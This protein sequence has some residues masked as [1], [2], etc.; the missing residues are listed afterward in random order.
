MLESK[1]VLALIPARGGSKGI[2]RKNIQDLGGHPLIW[3]SIQAALGSAYA[4]DCFVSTDDEEIAEVARARSAWVPFLRPAELAQDGSKTIDCMVEGLARLAEIGRRYDIVVLLQATSPFRTAADLDRALER[5]EECGERGLAPIGEVDV[6]PILMRTMAADGTLS[7][8]LAQGSTVR[9]R[10]MPT[11]HTVNGAIYINRAEEIRPDTSLNDNPVGWVLDRSR[12]LGIDEPADL[13]E[14]RK[15]I[16]QHLA[17]NGSL[18]VRV[19]AVPWE[20][21]QPRQ[22]AHEVPDAHDVHD[23]TR[24]GLEKCEA[25]GSVARH[26]KQRHHA[27][28]VEGEA[29][30]HVRRDGEWVRE[31]L[32][33]AQPPHQEGHEAREPQHHLEVVEQQAHDGAPDARD[34]AMG[35]RHAV[36]VEG[37]DEDDLELHREDLDD[38]Q[39]AVEGDEPAPWRCSRRGTSPRSRRAPPRGWRRPSGR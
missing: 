27:V 26:V 9:R 36:S 21:L 33:R 10:D 13:E 2:P 31:R 6:S 32:A 28:G 19:V 7:H 15:I 25:G 37:V 3:H 22:S 12:A 5:F 4:D 24:R 14:A 34:R 17:R 18:A 38:A 39:R 23:H 20:H 16:A 11:Y 1:R 8:L 30:E 29:P 35:P